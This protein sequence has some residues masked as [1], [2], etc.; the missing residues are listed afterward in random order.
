MDLTQILEQLR[1]QRNQLDS[2]ISALEGGQ[3]GARRG[4]PPKSVQTG[5][6]PKK[7]H[8]S[9][10]AR[11]KIAAAQRAR[12]AKQKG[13]TTSTKA[14]PLAAKATS[15]RKPMSAAARKRISAMMKKRWAARKKQR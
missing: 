13:S 14:A 7:R 12:W 5:P 8:M 2:A 6:A 15:G 1:R 11:A 9:V 3:T 10:A 4:R